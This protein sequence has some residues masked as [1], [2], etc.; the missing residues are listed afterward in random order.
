MLLAAL[1]TGCS[2]APEANFDRNAASPL[3]AVDRGNPEV[4]IV[5]PPNAPPVVLDAAAELANALTQITGVQFPEPTTEPA[6]TEDIIILLG[7]GIGDEPAQSAGLVDDAFRIRSTELSRSWQIDIR[8]GS[9]A[10]LAYGIYELAERLG[11][12]Y[13]HPE[14]TYYPDNPD[15]ELP[16]PLSAYGRPDLQLRGL[17]N[18]VLANG[19]LTEVLLRA[20]ER[21]SDILGRNLRWLVRNRMNLHAIEVLDSI[22]LDAWSQYI[23]EYIDD[24]HAL[25]V[26]VAAVVSLLDDRGHRHRLVTDPLQ[27]K[28]QIE[29]GLDELLIVPFDKLILTLE[30]SPLVRPDADQLLTWIE[31]VEAHLAERHQDTELFVRV[32]P[33]LDIGDG[34]GGSY[35]Q[36][37]AQTSANLAVAGGLVWSVDGTAQAHGATTYEHQQ[38]LLQSRSGTRKLLYTPR[39]ASAGGV[40]MDLP[41][42]LPVVG[43][44]RTADLKFHLNKTDLLGQLAISSG[45]AWGWWLMEL[46][47]AR[48]AWDRE[49]DWDST[50]TWLS[51]VL[52]P[53]ASP[54]KEWG[55]IQTRVLADE[56]PHL[57]WYLTGSQASDDLGSL[58]GEPIHPRRPGLLAVWSMGSEAFEAWRQDDLSPL[59][60][61][62]DALGAP[63]K[64][65]VEP[66]EPPTP[67]DSSRAL[68]RA[69]IDAALRVT[70]DRLNQVVAAYDMVVALR[71]PLADEEEQKARL[72]QLVDRE[73]LAREGAKKR[74]A[75]LE[76]V[77]LYPPELN[78]TITLSPSER[79]DNPPLPPL[80]THAAPLLQ[81]VSDAV[82]WERLKDELAQAIAAAGSKSDPTAWKNQPTQVFVAQSL[83]VLAPETTLATQLLSPIFGRLLVASVDWPQEGDDADLI[84]ALDRDG[85]GRPDAATQRSF[86]AGVHDKDSGKTVLAESEYAVPFRDAAGDTVGQLVLTDVVLT[87][88]PKHVAGAVQSI[89]GGTLEGQVDAQLLAELIAELAG[90]DL[91]TALALQLVKDMGGAGDGPF[92]L[93]VGL[94]SFTAAE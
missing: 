92:L 34:D 47:A 20:D 16:L 83:S 70:V 81:T 48:S 75:A 62:R 18:D 50:I 15:L 27:A 28:A 42:M 60:D 25:E 17:Q 1:L 55:E 30:S 87:L 53:Y 94:S 71:E 22:P 51:S 54:L 52:G 63:L 72:E 65:I 7:S 24:A 23:A 89:F 33:R 39:L 11:V 69:E 41:L 5:L 73:K 46:A 35:Y 77:Y 12:R 59:S 26:E 82:H 80:T 67:E 37:A 43:V 58:F 84:L 56:A 21:W 19:P 40:D 66:A 31:N 2:S 74:M 88:S 49:R 79:A 61:L 86:N 38:T 29:A 4:R 13:V 9:P 14:L 45:N 85:D 93:R 8:G 44:A 78:G 36:T 90:D 6:G 76:K 91:D 32:E 68:L 64:S 3:A 57:L 10:G